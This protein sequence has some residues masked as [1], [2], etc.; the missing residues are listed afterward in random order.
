MES[1]HKFY[2]LLLLKSGARRKVEN[3]ES[4]IM[5]RR[6]ERERERERKRERI[7]KN[8]L[9]GAA[10]DHPVHSLPKGRINM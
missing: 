2:I 9:G 4:M 8:V 1:L 6:E 3:L 10:G 7:I 5:K